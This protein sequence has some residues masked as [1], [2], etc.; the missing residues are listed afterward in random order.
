MFPYAGENILWR[1][2]Y[3]HDVLDQYVMMIGKAWI[4]VMVRVRVRARVRIRVR[5]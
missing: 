5:F 4:R 2:L 3:G 1:A